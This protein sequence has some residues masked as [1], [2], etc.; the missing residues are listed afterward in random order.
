VPGG[1]QGQ[2]AFG[3]GQ[4]QVLDLAQ[5]RAGRLF[6]HHVLAGRQG[7]VG[8]GVARLGRGAQR[9]RVDRHV[10][11]QQLGQGREVRDAVEV[12]VAADDGD[13]FEAVVGGDGGQVLVA[14]DLAQADE[15]EADRRH[16]LRTVTGLS[17]SWV[18]LG[19]GIADG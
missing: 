15:G 19:Q 1:L 14:G 9:H 5:R 2:A 12:G 10:A 18:G 16:R 4:A 13:Q 6:Q 17:L 8:Q 7:Q 11:G 3:G